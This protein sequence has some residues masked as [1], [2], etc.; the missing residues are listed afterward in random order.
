MLLMISKG[1]DDLMTHDVPMTENFEMSRKCLKSIEY[2]EAIKISDIIY[3]DI[4]SNIS[5]F[6]TGN[7]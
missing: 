4:G 1:H 6:D 3:S 2:S 7:V 5:T